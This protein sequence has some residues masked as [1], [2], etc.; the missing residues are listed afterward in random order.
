MA[1]IGRFL[2]YRVTVCDARAKFVTRE[3]FPVADDLVVDWPDRFLERSPVDERTVICVLTHDHKFDV[4]LLKLALGTNAGYI[5]AMGSRRT[6][7]ERAERLRA[8]EELARI[9]APIGLGIGAR[10]P[11]E[12][13]VAIAAQLV[14]VTRARKTE[15]VRAASR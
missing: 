11:Q 3:R 14:Q 1:A 2:G 12:V 9:H 8:D 13:A 4:P 15:L 10:T 5:G 6:S 7:D